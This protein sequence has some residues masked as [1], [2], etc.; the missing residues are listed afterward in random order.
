MQQFSSK[1]GSSKR[2]FRVFRSISPVMFFVSFF[3]LHQ[4]AEA[5]LIIG[6]TDFLDTPASGACINFSTPNNVCNGTAGDIALESV[7]IPGLPNGVD[8]VT[9]RG[10]ILPGQTGSVPFA[11]TGLYLKSVN[12]VPVPGMPGTVADL[13]VT[14]NTN[15]QFAIP[16][17][18]TLAPSNGVLNVISNPSSGILTFHTSFTVHSD[19]IFVKVG[20]SPTKIA[21][22]LFHSPAPAIMQNSSTISAAGTTNMEPGALLNPPATS[23]TAAAPPRN[24]VLSEFPEGGPEVRTF[25]LPFRVV[26]GDVVLGEGGAT[27]NLSSVNGNG[28]LA[29]SNWSDLIVF[30]PGPNNTSIVTFYSDP[31]IPSLC[32][33]AI[34]LVSTPTYPGSPHSTVMQVPCPGLVLSS[35]AQGIPEIGPEGGNAGFYH[36]GGVNYEFVSDVPEPAAS[37]LVLIGAASLLWYG[38]RRRCCLKPRSKGD[39]RTHHLQSIRTQLT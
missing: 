24:I 37:L 10:T 23:S 19:A 39:D 17:Y 11:L 7:S 1:I 9:Q 16:V 34:M 5:S 21:D 15:G 6:G 27:P 13:Y 31:A 3:V 25:I 8:T 20:T 30:A 22:V 32:A 33:S 26:P 4:A 29:G 35:N 12:P 2:S 14:V 28:R 38:A 36:P 18:D